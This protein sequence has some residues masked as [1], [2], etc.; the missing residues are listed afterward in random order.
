MPHILASMIQKTTAH[1][2]LTFM[3]MAGLAGSAVAADQSKGVQMTDADG[4]V[5]VEINGE[6]FTDYIYA[7]APHVYYYPVLGPGGVK[8]TRDYPMVRDSEGEEHD[9]PHHRSMWY[10]HGDVNGIDFW[11]EGAKAGKIVHD[12]FL[13]IKSG[14][15]SGV[16]RSTCKWIAPDGDVTCTDERTFRV[17]NRPGKERVFDFEVTIKAKDKPVI[18]GDTKEGSFGIRIAESMRFSH[19]KKPGDGH[20]VLSSGPLDDKAWGKHGEWCDYYGP[21]QGKTVGIAVFDHLEN[22]RHPTTWHVRDYGLF[23][24]NPFGLHD[25]EKAEK[26][27]G[28]MTIAAG[29][30]ATFRYRVYI[31]E[32]DTKAAKV[33]ER[34]KE[35]G[36]K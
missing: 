21:V 4:K 33:A 29:K 31:H 5:H 7:G 9:H 16:I 28:N 20:I 35:Y 27:A 25:F 10:S 15:E 3:A 13:E 8:M 18:L 22:P 23:A 26:G 1:Y 30:T 34:Y 11:S 12:K 36:V 19:G 2:F 24:A 14:E 32:G 17:Y 6:F